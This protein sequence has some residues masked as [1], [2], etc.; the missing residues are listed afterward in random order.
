MYGPIVFTSQC[1]DGEHDLP[2]LLYKGVGIDPRVSY[3]RDKGS[4]YWALAL[5]LCLFIPTMPVLCGE[6]PF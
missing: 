2:N 6:I 1:W 5:A 3:M 4:S